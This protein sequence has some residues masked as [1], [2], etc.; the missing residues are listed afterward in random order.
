L[1]ELRPYQTDVI[2]EFYQTTA[3]FKRVILVAP[4]GAGKTVIASAIIKEFVR[5]YREVLVL[6]HR[7][8][9]IGQTSKK[10]RELGIS[11]GIIQAGSPL[12]PLAPVQVASIST[13]WHRAIRGDRMALPPAKL[14]VIDE[15]HHAPARTYRKIID[16][17]P[18][19]IILG[20]TAT[21]CRGD[22]R[23]LGGIF[24]TII[25]C[26]QVAELIKQ[27]FLVKTR[28]YAPSAPDLVG[29]RVQA[30]D[31]IE[32]QL[33]KR[34]D[35]AKLVADI[36]GTWHKYGDGRRTVCFA[37]GVGHSIHLRDEF[38]ASGVR[39]EHIDGGTPKAERDE[40]LNRL[41]AGDIT[42]VTNCMVLTE[43][44]DMPDVG[45]CIL[46]RPTKKM[47]L[48][49][50]MVGRVLRPAP[51][52]QNAIILDHSGAVFR[53]GLPEDR[54]DWFL[55]PDAKAESP[56]HAARNSFG[57]AKLLDCSQCGALREGGKACPCCGFLPVRKPD[58]VIV[59]EGELTLVENGKPTKPDL[60]VNEW[61]AMLVAIGMEKGYKPG[62]AAYKFKEK[63]GNWPPARSVIPVDPSHEVR[64]WVRS[65][66]IAWLKS[67]DRHAS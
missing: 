54:V 32:S 33:A 37:T 13:L 44:W 17:Y 7:R 4:T 9:I 28:V 55:S 62:W 59:R 53:H 5:T 12:M 38:I 61:H 23:G 50:Q 66:T 3:E 41:A 24:E 1:N 29:V 47:G 56:T 67:K 6:A 46:A 20:L 11:H 48:F 31:Y 64:S 57:G 22:G 42:L 10:L 35:T 51:G 18:D 58:L 27:D 14:M 49:R 34:M 65:R 19:A 52:K 2:A 40:T 43:G 25:E 30:G 45:C 16:A 60:N 15:C 8:E 39:A 63:F 26:P 36:V 21:P